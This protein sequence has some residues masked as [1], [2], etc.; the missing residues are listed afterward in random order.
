MVTLSVSDIMRLDVC[1]FQK[2]PVGCHCLSV[3]PY[4][5]SVPLTQSRE[6]VHIGAIGQEGL[7]GE[8]YTKAQPR[9]A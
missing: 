3:W 9:G 5:A 8:S 7:T 4:L 6:E 1:E 2:D